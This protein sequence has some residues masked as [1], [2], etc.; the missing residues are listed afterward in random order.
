M[1]AASNSGWSSTHG[2][3]GE[4]NPRASGVDDDIGLEVEFLAGQF[5]PEPDSVCS[6]GD[7]RDVVAGSGASPG[8]PTPEAGLLAILQDIQGQSLRVVYGG[9]KVGCC[10]LD[11][12]VQLGKFSQGPGPATELVAGNAAAVTGEE[13][14]H[15]QTNLDEERTALLGLA[16]LVGEEARGSGQDSGEGTEDRDGGLQRLDV[17]GGDPEQP[18]SFNHRFLDQAELAVLEVADAAMDH[19]RRSAAGTLA[20]VAAFDKGYVDALESEVA[21]RSDAVDAT[22]DNEDLRRWPLLKC[23]D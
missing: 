13:V 3:V 7:E 15:A 16:L 18:V 2:L 19:V 9:I 1:H 17:V 5:V 14:V 4:V 6:H 11:T 8:K 22:A 12:G 23:D 20:V 10:V 21:E